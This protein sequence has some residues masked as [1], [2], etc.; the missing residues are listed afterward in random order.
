MAQATYEPERGYQAL[1]QLNLDIARVRVL[2][3]PLKVDVYRG[4]A[5]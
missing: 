4:Y 1:S 3:N 2:S 5:M